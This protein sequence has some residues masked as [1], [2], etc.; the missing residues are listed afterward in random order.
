VHVAREQGHQPIEIEP[1]PFCPTRAP[2]DLNA[3]GINHVVIDA[4]R[5]E[6]PVQPQPFAPG[7]ITTDHR[8]VGGQMESLLRVAISANTRSVDRA[9]TV[10][11]RGGCPKPM[12]ACI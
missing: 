12:R 7:L 4:L 9:G 8:R 2:I 6:P 11:M 5:D 10:R 3:G 1:N